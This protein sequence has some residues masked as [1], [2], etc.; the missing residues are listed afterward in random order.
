MKALRE[1]DVAVIHSPIG[2]G[3]AEAVA[4]WVLKALSDN[5]RTLLVTGLPVDLEGVSAH[6][7]VD[8][9]GRLPRTISVLDS[10]REVWH[11]H[12]LLLHHLVMR[13]A[14]TKLRG[15]LCVS[16]CNEMSFHNMGVQYIHF[17]ALRHQQACDLANASELA[18]Q[19]SRSKAIAYLAYRTMCGVISGYDENAMKRNV[20]MVNS[21]WTG[22]IVKQLYGIEAQTVYPPVRSDFP[23]APWEDRE[24]GF[25]CVGRVS[26]EKRIERAITIVEGVRAR[27]HSVHLHI[28]GP[29]DDLR[30]YRELARLP[31][32]REGW[33][34]FEGGVSRQQLGDFVG[35]HRFG[36]HAMPAE[37][38][39][40]AVAE[41]AKAGC[42][43]FAPRNG[44]Q[45]E[46]VDY[47]ER[48][49]YGDETE[50]VERIDTVLVNEKMQAGLSEKMMACG[51]RYSPAR[52]VRE[53][54]EVVRRVS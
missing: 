35:G 45:A 36:L 25:V 1:Y 28:I 21:D 52:F 15:V 17:P 10:D 53:V 19:H 12:G 27:G 50:A 40:I 44:G 9:S 13:Y 39:G 24:V 41:M 43:V 37:H 54:R 32:A 46:I 38:F 18:P 47:D 7:G 26:R 2:I 23:V 22:R 20:T 51:G 42:I 6:L 34:L 8:F 30:Y 14:R 5:Y 33:A 16:T 31:G 48:L 4:L 11:R 3:G 49:L 29:I